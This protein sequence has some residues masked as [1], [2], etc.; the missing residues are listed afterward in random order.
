MLAKQSLYS[1]ADS[2]ARSA[3]FLDKLAAQSS[4]LMYKNIDL[5]PQF[6]FNNLPNFRCY[7]L[8]LRD[9][10]LPSFSTYYPTSNLI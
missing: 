1:N 4:C 8:S 5:E 7:I 2:R 3:L 6:I 10:L 9:I